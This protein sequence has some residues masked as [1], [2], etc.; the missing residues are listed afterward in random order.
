M[1]H[2]D[3][4][5]AVL[6]DRVAV[7]HFQRFGIAHVDFLLARPPFAF[8]VLHRDSRRLHALAHR[9]HHRLFAGG[10][11]DVVVLDVV[12]GGFRIAVVAAMDVLVAFVEQ[13]EL[14]LR[15]E[16][17]DVTALGKPGDL[18]LQHGPRAMRKI[19]VFVVQHIAQHQRGAVQPRDAAQGFQVGFEREVAIALVPARRGIAGHRFHVDVVG[20]QVVAAVGFVVRAVQKELGLEALADQTALHVDHAGQHRVDAAVGDGALEFGEAEGCGHLGFRMWEAGRRR[21]RAAAASTLLRRRPAACAPA[22]TPLLATGSTDADRARR[23][24]GFP[25]R[26]RSQPTSPPRCRRGP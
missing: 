21:L 12:A 18:F 19:A 17:A 25:L 11:Q 2:G 23:S 15:G 1:L 14:Q 26:T 24:T 7:G 6:H 13:V 9:P 10:L 20:E 3:L 22:R 8:G 5:A 16:H 4:L